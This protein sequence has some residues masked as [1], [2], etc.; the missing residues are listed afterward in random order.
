MQV[1]L[2]RHQWR[3]LK[4]PE[5]SLFVRSAFYLGLPYLYIQTRV[6]S[7]SFDEDRLS[8]IE[9]AEELGMTDKDKVLLMI[10]KG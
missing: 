4:M 1:L 8:V 10:K 6:A 7:P 9:S 2:T 5:Y 3:E